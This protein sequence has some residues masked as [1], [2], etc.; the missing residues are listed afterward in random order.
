MSKYD[1]KLR[2]IVLNGVAVTKHGETVAAHTRDGDYAEVR[3]GAK[4]DA[5]T[6][7]LYGVIDRFRCSIHFDS[8]I[9][10]QIVSWAENHTYIT[11]QCTD[12]NTGEKYTCTTATIQNIADVND[13]DDREF[14]VQCEEPVK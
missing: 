5:I 3:R 7:C 13:G 6:N 14:T 10:S 9:F 4:G 12:D 11:L 1:V 2:D 8:P